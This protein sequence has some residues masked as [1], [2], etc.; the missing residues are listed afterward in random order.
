MR[1][2]AIILV[3]T[4]MA[5]GSLAQSP[6][7]PCPSGVVRWKEVGHKVQGRLVEAPVVGLSLK[8]QPLG[9]LATQEVAPDTPGLECRLR[10]GRSGRGALT[11][12]IIGFGTG[13]LLAASYLG[14][15]TWEDPQVLVGGGLEFAAVGALI[16][17]AVSPL[18]IWAPL[19]A[20]AGSRHVGLLVDGRGVGV[21]VQF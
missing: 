13:A 19:G 4:A 16:G 5:T 2:L 8:V 11:G 21:R 18:S 1:A 14:D 10:Q 12:A 20:T 6:D 9:A 15:E 7:N 17:A 3:T